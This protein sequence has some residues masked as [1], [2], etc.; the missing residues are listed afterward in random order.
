MQIRPSSMLLRSMVGQKQRTVRT[1]ARATDT[2]I[3]YTAQARLSATAG[4]LAAF[5]TLATL[6]LTLSLTLARDGQH[7]APPPT[8]TPSSHTLVMGSMDATP[9]C[10][11]LLG[12]ARPIAYHSSPPFESKPQRKCHARDSMEYGPGLVLYAL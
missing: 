11:S 2:L 10:P 1:R 7:E 12:L 8:H 4:P 5:F 9:R 6:V 3:P